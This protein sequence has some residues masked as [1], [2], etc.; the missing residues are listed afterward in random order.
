MR[1]TSNSAGL[2]SSNLDK[3][4]TLSTGAY[5]LT[6]YS[7]RELKKVT[8]LTAPI[9]LPGNFY[10]SHLALFCRQE[11]KLQKFSGVPFRFRIG[12]LEHCNKL[13]GK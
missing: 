4:L 5:A 13:E 1:F 7:S 11:F 2:N 12:L 6:P 9:G 3:T 10:A 8:A